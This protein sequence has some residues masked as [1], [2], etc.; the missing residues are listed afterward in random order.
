MVVSCSFHIIVCVCGL[1]FV[2]C[3]SIWWFYCFQMVVVCGVGLL[4][5]LVHVVRCV[6]AYCVCGCINVLFGLSYVC[7]GCGGV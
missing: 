7:D 5:A 3:G 1:C 2:R 4:A 6:V